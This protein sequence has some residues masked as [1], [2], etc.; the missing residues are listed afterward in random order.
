MLWLVLGYIQA[1]LTFCCSGRTSLG[2]MWRFREGGCIR[3]GSRPASGMYVTSLFV[4]MIV[5]M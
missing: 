3:S 1:E 2:D 4:R 5:I